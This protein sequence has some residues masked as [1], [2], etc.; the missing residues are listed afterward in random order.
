MGLDPEGTLLKVALY[1][2]LAGMGCGLLAAL[3]IYTG[4]RGI[5]PSIARGRIWAD[6]RR[7]RMVWALSLSLCA[8]TA[9]LAA[10]TICRMVALRDLYWLN[11]SQRI[12]P[13]SWAGGLFGYSLALAG[14]VAAALL[15]KRKGK[16][17]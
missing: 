4:S 12:F 10:D 13:I 2:C 1:S 11:M 17:P 16:R 15:A 5:R 8:Y 3:L 14:F 7:R 6:W 9:W